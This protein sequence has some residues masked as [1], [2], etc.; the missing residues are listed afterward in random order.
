MA[1]S[2]QVIHSMRVQNLK[3]LVDLE[4]SFDASPVTAI[5]GP[6][7]NG[8]STI[9]HALACA[10]SPS[11]GGENYKFSW[12]FLP[13]TDA[14]WNG[15]EMSIIHS[16]RED[17]NEHNNITR[18]YKKTQVRWTPR[19]ANRPLRDVFYIGIDKCVPM[20]EAEKK[21]AK[22]NYSTQVV[23]EE[24]INT[25]LEK[26]SIVLNRRYAS[27]HVHEA[28][29]KEFIGVEVDGLR[30]S[31]LSM[32]AG[33]QKVFYILE[34]VFRAKRYS[35]I[36]IDELDLLLHDQA[37]KKLIDVI[38]ERATDKNLQVIFTTHRESVLDL[39]DKI[40]IRHIVCRPGKTLC[41]NE[42]KPDA[43][44]RLTGVQPRPLEVFVEDDLASTIVKKVASQLRLAKY[45]T[46][47]RYGAA[48]NCFTTVG[49]LLLGGEPCE[50]SLFMLD[51]D[52][53]RTDNDKRT[54]INRVLTGHDENV[55][56]ARETALSAIKQFTLPIDT[57]PEK[58]LHSLII[59]M[60]ETED[61]ERNEIIE[62]AKEIVVVDEDHKYVNEIIHRL[63]WE[64]A[65]GLSKIVDLV[66]TTDEWSN[67]T[68][69]LNVWLESKSA[70]LREDLQVA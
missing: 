54:S 46:T 5:L 3:N 48:I 51:G 17:Q 62:V 55:V 45:V 12:F 8:K 10:F 60:D 64:R 1:I 20:I 67:Y 32:S 40:N 13:N 58:Y 11:D 68:N 47:S 41:F 36:L 66:A 38:L 15:S 18:E 69:D 49:G 31:A 52:V 70:R 14:L 56:L 22:I 50:N 6:N 7:G 23:N 37:M 24:I 27:Y 30:Y 2:Q 19:Y 43:I 35:L 33:E 25:I 4:I 61:E 16:Y 26:A 44:N 63:G 34:K 39:E 29:G 53:Y 65:T 59:A 9:L 57:K 42:T 21:Q 28:S